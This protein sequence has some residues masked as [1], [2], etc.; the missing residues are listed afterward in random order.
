MTT[1]GFFDFYNTIYTYDKGQSVIN[2]LRYRKMTFSHWAEGL[3]KKRKNCE[4][5]IFTCFLE[6]DK[7]KE[8]LVMYENRFKKSLSGYARSRRFDVEY[9]IKKNPRK[10]F[11]RKYHEVR[12]RQ[13]ELILEYIEKVKNPNSTNPIASAEASVDNR[14]PHFEGRTVEKMTKVFEYL[15]SKGHL[16]GNT[17]KE[18]FIYY[19]TGEGE[20]PSVKLKWRTAKINTAI[21][22]ETLFGEAK[23][24]WD[25]TSYIFDEKNN[26]ANI[27]SRKYNTVFTAKE[28]EF[29]NELKE[30]IK[31]ATR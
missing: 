1:K 3:F 31:S 26:Y 13:I 23:K 2:A 17:A 24:K 4:A 19:F 28:Q 8:Q 7:F 9:D 29:E 6:N 30:I 16:D 14:P 18:D 27:Y 10:F 22:I 11:E 15:I 25:I 20:I 5:C 12:K 21:F